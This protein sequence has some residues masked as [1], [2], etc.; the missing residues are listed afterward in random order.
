MTEGETTLRNPKDI[1]WFSRIHEI[2]CQSTHCI[3]R[4]FMTTWDVMSKES[5]RVQSFIPV[6]F[7]FRQVFLLVA[8]KVIVVTSDCPL[9]TIQRWT[10]L[11][12]SFFFRWSKSQTSLNKVLRFVE[13]VLSMNKKYRC[14]NVSIFHIIIISFTN[15]VFISI[16][17]FWVDPSLSAYEEKEIAFGES[18]SIFIG[19]QYSSVMFRHK[20]FNVIWKRHLTSLWMIVFAW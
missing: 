9:N 7:S 3:T 19:Y 8:R 17:F 4:E 1:N 14:W 15:V 16:C 10:F 13:T 12:I 11:P 20:L 18:S 6:R 2:F 5:L